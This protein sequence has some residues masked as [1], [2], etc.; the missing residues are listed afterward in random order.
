MIKYFKVR[1]IHN[2]I[3]EVN[4]NI[5]LPQGY[6]F[7]NFKDGDQEIWAQIE[8]AAGE[9]SSIYKALKR[10]RYEFTGFET[11]LRSRCFFLCDRNDR[12]IGTSMGWY[13]QD[14]N[15]EIIGRLHWIAIHPDYQGKKLGKPLVARAI[16]RMQQSH[17]KAYL[18][19]QTTSWKAINMYLDFGFVP[20]YTSDDC[21][22]A[23]KLL[24]SKLNR[25][26]SPLH[27]KG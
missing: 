3:R 6:Y 23:W 24:A 16:K 27:Q 2:N 22:I 26:I 12:A 5:P 11:E 15:G 20:S 7:R 21:K 4:T 18:T 10:F 9:F 17:A 19:S 8:T 25:K 13:G 14:L 1:M